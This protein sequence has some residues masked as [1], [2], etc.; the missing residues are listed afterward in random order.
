MNEIEVEDNENIEDVEDTDDVINGQNIEMNLDT[1]LHTEIEGENDDH[2]DEES[3]DENALSILC[4]Q[5][6]TEIEKNKEI[7][8]SRPL[9]RPPILTI[10]VASDMNSG[11]TS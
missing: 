9:L 2:D 10:P 6:L 11:S 7:T 3:N 5:M 8:E 1:V 4:E